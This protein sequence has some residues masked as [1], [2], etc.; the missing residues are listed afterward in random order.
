MRDLF[1]DKL[2]RWSVRAAQVLMLLLL[3]AAI[4]VVLIPLKLVVIPVV[5]A[6]ILAAA[7]APLVA[8]LRGVGVHPL[9]AAWIVLVVAVLVL[10]GI[11][12]GIVFAVRREWSTIV[13][14]AVEGFEE[15]T[16]WLQTLPLPIESIDQ[17]AV[18]QQLTDFVTSAQFGS[19]A[20]TGLSTA[21]E[22]VTGAIL[23]VIVL[24][25][26][27]KDGDRI[28][29]FLLARTGATGR[30]RGERIG[31]VGVNVLGGYARGTAIVAAVDAVV[32]GAALLILQVPLAI[33]L[34]ALVFLGAFIPIVGATVVGILAALVAL[35]T[36]G[37]TAAIIVAIVIVLVN[38]LEGDLLQPVVMSQSVR[39]HPLVILLA[40]TAGTLV[41]GIVGAVLA[42]PI[43]ALAWSIISIWNE[44]PGSTD[45]EGSPADG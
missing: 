12:T 7:G 18:L 34:A 45:E 13:D 3:C 39:L 41:G 37:L 28:W 33:P 38:Q 11:V 25:F 40:L 14:S 26:L 30:A 27:L 15:L 19:G 42:V 6:T 2:G 5:I 8:R 44:S 22:I 4:V 10:G 31:R 1:S 9:L 16:R 23:V 17:D 24:F 36:N 20:I 32:I 35:V 43:T 21:V 29:D